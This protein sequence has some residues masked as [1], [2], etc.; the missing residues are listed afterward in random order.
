MA[1]FYRGYEETVKLDI[2][3]I[4][5]IQ[6]LYQPANSSIREMSNEI[7]EEESPV[8]IFPRTDPRD[9][10]KESDSSICKSRHFDVILTDMEGR[11]FV[12]KV[13][14]S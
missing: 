10:V 5:G 8:S 13:S 9:R 3:D 11:T 14:Q 12:F 1:P 2:D 6:E 4:R 7:S